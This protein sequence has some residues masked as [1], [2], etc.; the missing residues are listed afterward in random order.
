MR[1][2]LAAITIVSLGLAPA[3]AAGETGPAIEATNRTVYVTVVD[4]QGNKVP[5]LTPADLVVKEN[6]KER[7]IVKVEPASPRM[8][9]A[10]A[11]EER[12][13]GE[14]SVRAAIF[15]FVKR[16]VTGADIS[17]ITVGLSNQTLVDYT[18]NVNT[19]V[20]AINKLT[21][22]PRKDSNLSEGVL[23][24][25]KTFATTKSERPVIVVV[26]LAGGQ[27]GVEP[28]TVLDKIGQSGATMHAVTFGAGGGS[29]APVGAMGDE[30]GRE[31]VLSDGPKQS[32]GRRFDLTASSA[33][34]KTLLQVADDLEAQYA[35]TYVLPDGVKPSKRLNVTT[36][37]KGVSLRAPSVVP[38]R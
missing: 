6:G 5:D 12:L 13:V 22:N 29:S 14:P 11:V 8:R 37:K 23:E 15:E 18:N 34:T 31:Q 26:A 19:L 36:K 2:Q 16:M 24:L 3:V 35:V 25:A 21:L 4:G 1:Q 10:L 7:E 9:L 30:S 33:M 20:D 28:K 17:L 27:A 38:D 32:G